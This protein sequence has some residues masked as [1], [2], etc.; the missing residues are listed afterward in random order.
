MRA[1][2]GAARLGPIEMVGQGSKCGGDLAT[3]RGK[4]G[5]PRAASLVDWRPQRRAALYYDCPP[6]QPGWQGN[7]GYG[8]SPAAGSDEASDRLRGS[9]ARCRLTLELAGPPAETEIQTEALPGASAIAQKRFG[10]Y[11]FTAS[12]ATAG[13][14]GGGS[15]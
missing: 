2:P 14:E 1:A 7:N 8:A 3:V 5:G 9:N 10:S 12:H 13:R 4:A 15:R 6:E 11:S